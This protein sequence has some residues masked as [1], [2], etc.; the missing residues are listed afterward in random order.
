MLSV[1]SRLAV[2]LPLQR[3]RAAERV[4]RAAVGWRLPAELSLAVV[5]AVAM[6]RLSRERRGVDAVTDV[7]S[8]GPTLT[9][10][11]VPALATGEV[12]V[13]LPVAQSQAR[14]LGHPWREELVVL[15]VHGLLHVAGYD[16][17]RS[18]DTVRL[19]RLEASI[20]GRLGMTGR[21]LV[22]RAEGRPPHPQPLSLEGEGGSPRTG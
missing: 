16:H 18:A 7:L 2:T 21:G 6:R 5:G 8:F 3:L 13:C 10:A 19:R 12:V 1:A 22:E 9:P 4:T 17:H 15:L 14:R 11:H 20:L